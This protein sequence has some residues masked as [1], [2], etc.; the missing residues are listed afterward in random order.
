MIAMHQSETCGFYGAQSKHYSPTLHL[1]VR[2]TLKFS[3][4]HGKY[5]VACSLNKLACVCSL[6]RTFLI[7][8]MPSVLRAKQDKESAKVGSHLQHYRLLQRS[9]LLA[10]VFDREINGITPLL[11]ILRCCLHR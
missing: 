3:T 1:S 8:M 6:L 2:Q 7:T 4:I 11:W 9:P 10:D 5:I